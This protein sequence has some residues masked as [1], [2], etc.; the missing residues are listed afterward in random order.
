MRA[1]CA[2]KSASAIA[3]PSPAPASIS[4]SWPCSTIS[5]TPAGVIATRYSSGLISVGTPIFIAT[6]SLARSASQN[7]IR[8]WARE[9][10]R[11]VSSSTL[12]IR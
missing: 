4:T 2:S 5:R 1:P 6:S 12:R 9:R 10:S 11:P 3:L 7:S 8:S